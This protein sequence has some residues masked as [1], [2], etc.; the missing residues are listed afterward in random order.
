MMMPWFLEADHQALTADISPDFLWPLGAE[1]NFF[2]QFGAAFDKS[3]SP[4]GVMNSYI[5]PF[6]LPS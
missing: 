5:L 1:R 4:A 3:F 2:T 6:E